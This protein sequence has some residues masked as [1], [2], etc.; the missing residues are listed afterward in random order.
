MRLVSDICEE[1]TVLHVGGGLSKGEPSTVLAEPQVIT[2][3]L[4]E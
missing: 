2:A 3:Y 4:G 1:L